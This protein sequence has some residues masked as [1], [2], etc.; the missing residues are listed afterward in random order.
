MG[1]AAHS[2]LAGAVLMMLALA[3]VASVIERD[4]A[5]GAVLLDRAWGL[6]F[7]ALGLLAMFGVFMP[8][9]GAAATRGRSP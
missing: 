3:S 4:R 5:I 7:P 8:A 1:M 6:V 9:P 2:S